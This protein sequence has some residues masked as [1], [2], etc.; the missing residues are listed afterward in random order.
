M[1]VHF[2]AFVGPTR[3]FGQKPRHAAHPL[4]GGVHVGNTLGLVMPGPY[5]TR[6]HGRAHQAL[7]LNGDVADKF[8]FGKG[9]IH[10]CAVACLELDRCVTRRLGVQLHRARRGGVFKGDYNVQGVVVDLCQLGCVL[11]LQGR[12][13]HHPGHGL[14]HVQNLVMRQH[15]HV[16]HC[17]RLSLRVFDLHHIGQVCKARGLHVLSGQH[18]SHT[19]GAEHRAQVQAGDACMCMARANHMAIEHTHRFCVGTELTGASDQALVFLAQ[20]SA[21]GD[22]IHGASPCMAW[23]A[24]CTAR[25]MLTYPVQRHRLPDKPSAICAGVG[26]GLR[27]SKSTDAITI[28]GVQKPH[29]NP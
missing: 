5:C 3:D 20:Q 9:R 24:C 7:A 1:G 28:P 2:H 21:R 27:R 6:L 10:R 18:L 11:R 19:R 4:G 25:M 8:G 16:A 26:L 14:A 13:G 15:R 12:V 17:L 23:L 22:G 29:C